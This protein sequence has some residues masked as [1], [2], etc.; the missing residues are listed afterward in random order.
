MDGSAPGYPEC[1]LAVFPGL[2]ASPAGNGGPR[3]RGEKGWEK[4]GIYG[5][6]YVMMAVWQWPPWPQPRSTLTWA[7]RS[8]RLNGPPIQSGIDR[9]IT[10]SCLTGAAIKFDS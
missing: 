8:F 4:R 5:H 9:S 2:P 7:A 3:G 1:G 6:H 10:K